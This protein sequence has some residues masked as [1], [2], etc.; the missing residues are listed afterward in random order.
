[1]ENAESIFRYT[2]GMDFTQFEQDRKTDAVERCLQRT[3][4]AV[5]R[6]GDQAEVLIPE[7]PWHRI[8]GFGNRLRHN[9]DS[10]EEDR[11]FDIGRRCRAESSF[12][13]SQPFAR[14]RRLVQPPLRASHSA[15]PGAT[16]INRQ[17]RT[18]PREPSIVDWLGLTRYSP[19]CTESSP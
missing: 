17:H 16:A 6:L 19:S 14:I 1:V 10:I 9:Y 13:L 11:L 4:E 15:K 8:R 7:V 2:H 18:G 3:T 12:E 5:I